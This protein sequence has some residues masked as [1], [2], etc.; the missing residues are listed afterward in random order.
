MSAR[1]QAR[2]RLRHPDGA[3]LSA[4]D[5][6]HAGAGGLGP[7]SVSVVFSLGVFV[8]SFLF[9][10]WF[11]R[12]PITDDPPAISPNTGRPGPSPHLA[13]IA[14]VRSGAWG[15]TF[16]LVAA[17]THFVGTAVAYAIGQGATMVS[18]SGVF[19]SGGNSPARRLLRGVCWR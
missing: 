10:T 19:L 6:I 14:G 2:N 8:S 5:Q 12:R 11:M 4:G 18:A 13:G 15:M 9:N 17:T 7:Y 16:S 1:P 3:V